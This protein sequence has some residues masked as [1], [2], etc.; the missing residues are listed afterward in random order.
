MRYVYRY[1]LTTRARQEVLAYVIQN[2]PLSIH[3]IY[4]AMVVPN[5]FGDIVTAYIIK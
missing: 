2:F 3:D 1:T 4:E 5:Y